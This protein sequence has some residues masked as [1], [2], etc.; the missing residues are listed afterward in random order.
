MT[1]PDSLHLEVGR[2]WVALKAK[3]GR[4]CQGKTCRIYIQRMVFIFLGSG[5]LYLKS[6]NE[7][8]FHLRANMLQLSWSL[9][10]YQDC[11]VG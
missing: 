4:D 11:L 5:C 6:A 2:I 7:I 10:I 8:H 9:T 1:W 3:C